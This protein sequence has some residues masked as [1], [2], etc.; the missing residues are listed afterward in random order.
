MCRQ[1]L[2]E[3]TAGITAVPGSVAG[4][5]VL[6]PAAYVWSFSLF[7]V[8]CRHAQIHVWR[9]ADAGGGG[10]KMPLHPQRRQRAQSPDSSVTDPSFRCISPS[11]SSSSSFSSLVP[12]TSC[13]TPAPPLR[14]VPLCSRLS[15]LRLR[16][17]MLHTSAL[18]VRSARFHSLFS[19]RYQQH[20]SL[21]LSHRGED[22]GG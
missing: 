21:L 2:G 20:L 15:S 4:T 14:C 17:C 18:S 16:L 19:R 7:W 5:T 6:L 9:A 12:L 1:L 22:K 3:R 10:L 13:F 11:S 8:R